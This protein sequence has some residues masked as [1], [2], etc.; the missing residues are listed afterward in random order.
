MKKKIISL[1]LT[2]TIILSTS[3]ISTSAI[4]IERNNSTLHN[5][6]EDVLKSYFDANLES[7]KQL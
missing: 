2:V 6:V 1:I 5:A 4:E 7:E 3:S